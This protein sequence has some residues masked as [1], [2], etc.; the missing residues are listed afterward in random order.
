MDS[1]VTIHHSKLTAEIGLWLGVGF[2]LTALI[3]AVVNRGIIDKEDSRTLTSEADE[4]DG[5]TSSESAEDLSAG[6]AQR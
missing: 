5:E 6:R 1:G 2:G 4:P 3:W